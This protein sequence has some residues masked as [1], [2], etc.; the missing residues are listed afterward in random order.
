MTTPSDDELLD[1]PWLL[2]NAPTASGVHV[3]PVDHF[4]HAS[5]QAW[6]VLVVADGRPTL[7]TVRF[8][9]AEAE[10]AGMLL[11]L[12]TGEVQ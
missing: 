7:I 5:L 6:A 1:G 3:R 10:A 4:V 8:D 2:T 11:W 12:E 9:R